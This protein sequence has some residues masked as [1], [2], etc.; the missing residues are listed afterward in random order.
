MLIYRLQRLPKQPLDATD[1]SVL[2]KID[3]RAV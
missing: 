2:D 3:L 1:K